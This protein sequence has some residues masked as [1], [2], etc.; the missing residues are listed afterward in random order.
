M[1]AKPDLPSMGMTVMLPR[2]V[3]IAG[4]VIGFGLVVYGLLQL[5]FG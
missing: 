3:W 4:P 1:K 2:L 5:A